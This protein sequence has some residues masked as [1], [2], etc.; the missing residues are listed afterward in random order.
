MTPQAF[1]YQAIDRQ[2]AMSRGVL[3]APNEAALVRRLS[4]EGLTVLK[5]SPAAAAQGEG[6]NRPLKSGER[7]LVLRQ[8]GLMLEAGVSLLESLDTVA[9]G[10]QSRK[11]KEQFLAAIAAL[12][13]GD[14]LG[15]ALEEHVPG[16]PDYLYAMA[17]VGEASG[18]VAEV[19]K[20]AAE[21]MAYEDRLRKDFGNAMTY[22]A[23][24]LM[25]GLGAVAFIFTQVV[26]RF[27][28]MIGEDRSRVPT[29]S[30]WVLSAGEFANANIGVI[31]IGLGALIALVVVIATNPAIKARA[32]T[33]AHGLPVV[34]GV[35]QA[36]E[37][38]A[39]ARL[40]SFALVNG[41]PI[42]SAVALAR[43]AVPIGP[44]RQGLN[45]LEND[46]KAGLTLDASLA[47]HTKLEAMDLSLLRAGQRSGAIGAMFG[48][49]AD[50]YENRLRDSMKRMTSLLE[51]A[52]I[53][54][55]SLIVGFVALSLVL[56][57][58]SVY[59]GVV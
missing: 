7:V 16:F 25:A 13:R 22:P 31:G 18:R 52:A 40:T 42:L 30:R 59:E 36:R 32:Y 26:P 50:N 43:A 47:A 41:V 45:R 27:G 58:S 29:V 33:L 1:Q 49:M 35:L 55:I 19:L 2:G 17:R 51:P 37:I 24:L 39:W 5:V 57:L 23:F 12:R 21:Q 15:K 4:A 54:A 11:G 6:Q 10:M 9:Q 28:A 3:T 38:A 34:G 48:F 44:F 20:Q 46:L 53:G 8:L 56:A 14:S